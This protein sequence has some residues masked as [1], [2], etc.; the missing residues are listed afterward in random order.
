MI[1]EGDWKG[2]FTEG[3]RR[4]KEDC[5]VRDEHIEELKEKLATADGCTEDD[6]RKLLRAVEESFPYPEFPVAN[7][8]GVFDESAKKDDPRSE[9]CLY[10]KRYRQRATVLKLA[11]M[12]KRSKTYIKST[13]PF[14]LPI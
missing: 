7:E 6:V 9:V 11:R 8:F 10:Q 1:N 12:N 4:L 14:P 5:K 3:A 13:V 2:D